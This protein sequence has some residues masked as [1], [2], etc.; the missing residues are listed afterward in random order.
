MPVIVAMNLV[1]HCITIS[2]MWR[3]EH[4]GYLQGPDSYTI[5]AGWFIMFVLMLRRF[6][7]CDGMVMIVVQLL[8]LLHLYINV[9]KVGEKSNHKLSQN[10][11]HI[12][13]SVWKLNSKTLSFMAG[14]PE[15]KKSEHATPTVILQKRHSHGW[16]SY[17]VDLWHA[18]LTV[19]L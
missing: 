3:F 8:L 14:C 12:F 13:I 2:T 9:L 7:W 6:T 17:P 4:Y 1:Q 18:Y 19:S 16:I 10:K 5:V 15:T 11:L